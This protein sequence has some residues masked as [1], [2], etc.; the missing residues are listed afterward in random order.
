MSVLLSS[1][2]SPF[3]LF[4]CFYFISTRGKNAKNT[5]TF[6]GLCAGLFFS[7]VSPLSFAQHADISQLERYT[8]TA[9][10]PYYDESLSR[11]F[12]Q[13]QFDKKSPGDA[14]THQRTFVASAFRIP[15]RAGRSD[16]KY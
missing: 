5:V 13:Y 10:R 6:S 7:F 1:Y 15:Q 14:A 12:P 8:V 2:S 9:T 11:I 4:L 16:T 3:F